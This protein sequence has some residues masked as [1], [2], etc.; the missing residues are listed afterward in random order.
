MTDADP[1]KSAVEY[2]GCAALC[3]SV[4][5]AQRRIGWWSRIIAFIHRQQCVA[6]LRSF[7]G[8][9]SGWKRTQELDVEVIE[10]PEHAATLLT[11]DF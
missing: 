4:P 11:R 5:T 6:D 10:H 2:A 7:P 3:P 1:W 8:V 9:I